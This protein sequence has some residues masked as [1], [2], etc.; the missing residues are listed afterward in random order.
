MKRVAKST[1]KSANNA[2][3]SEYQLLPPSFPSLKPFISM[4][5]SF[6]SMANRKIYVKQCFISMATRN[7][8]VK[9]CFIS[10]ATRNI[11]VKECFI[12]IAS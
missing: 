6:I 12:S 5:Y 9:E 2:V 7:I 10:I 3:I 11:Y 4:S 1:R 8:Y